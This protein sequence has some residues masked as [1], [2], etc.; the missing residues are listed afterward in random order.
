MEWIQAVDRVLMR[1]PRYFVLLSKNS[2]DFPHY[3]VRARIDKRCHIDRQSLGR[4]TWV[5]ECHVTPGPRI[6]VEVPFLQK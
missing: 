5:A 4:R 6:G 2:A 3:A 1:M